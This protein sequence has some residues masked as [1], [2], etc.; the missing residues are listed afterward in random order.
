MLS[1]HKLVYLI[2]GAAV[3]SMGLLL[4]HLFNESY[5]NKENDVSE[6]S[7]KMEAMLSNPIGI[8]QYGLSVSGIPGEYRVVEFS[9]R[10][11]HHCIMVATKTS[12]QLSC[13]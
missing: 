6:D 11:G 2:F 10:K 3:L 8:Q 4:F 5:A 12:F 13:H 9:D 1:G 7:L